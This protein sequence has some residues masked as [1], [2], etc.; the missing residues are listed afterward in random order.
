MPRK[1]RAAVIHAATDPR[2]QQLVGEVDSVLTGMGCKVAVKQAAGAKAPDLA[3][4]DLVLL[5]S[6]PDGAR[7]IHADFTELLRELAGMTLAGRAVGA[8]SLDA[9]STLRGFREALGDCEVPLPDASFLKA[10]G[11]T[12]EGD[13]AAW[14]RPLVQQAEESVRGR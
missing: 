1:V 4:A 12:R 9:D 2:M 10:G 6:S 8:F 3:A 13:L 11:G 7:P 14:L 5:G